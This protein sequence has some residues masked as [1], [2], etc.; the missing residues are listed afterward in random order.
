[1]EEKYFHISESALC[2]PVAPRASPRL[3]EGAQQTLP[4]G[5]KHL[6]YLNRRWRSQSIN[7]S[8]NNLGM[9]VHTT[10]SIMGNYI[11]AISMIII[12]MTKGYTLRKEKI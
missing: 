8:K 4:D 1:M 3:P 9:C 11:P 10:I 2:N 6:L 7:E 5:D 12:L